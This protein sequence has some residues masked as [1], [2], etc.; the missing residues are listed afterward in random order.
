MGWERRGKGRY[1][2]RKKRVNGKVVSEYIGANLVAQFYAAH[3]DSARADN[4]AAR[5]KD[6]PARLKEA[7]TDSRMRE[8]EG[9]INLL[10][11]DWLQSHGFHKHKGQWRK[12]RHAEKNDITGK[13]GIPGKGN[14][15]I[16]QKNHTGQRS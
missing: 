10:V 14:P 8:L 15:G 2:Y 5:R 12:R 16:E 6:L 11:K 9:N 7:E 4:I 13:T 1:Y 3:L